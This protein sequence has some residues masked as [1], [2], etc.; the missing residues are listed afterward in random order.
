[1]SMTAAERQTLINA[2]ALRVGTASQLSSRF[3]IPVAE[4]RTFTATNLAA[5]QAAERRLTGQEDEP[6]DSTTVTP[7]QLEDLWITNKFE[8]LK[9]LQEI[10]DETYSGINNGSFSGGADLAMAV[11]EFRSY[12][13]LAAN[14]L[15]QLLHRGSGDGGTGDSLSIDIAGVDMNSLR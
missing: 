3:S 7:Q 6:T 1:M 11:R 5:I 12:L 2:I 10:A 9:R 13:M 4:L 8:R 15:G 14:E